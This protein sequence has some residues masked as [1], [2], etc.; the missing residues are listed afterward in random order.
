MAAPFLAMILLEISIRTECALFFIN[1]LS[2]G[3]LF[4]RRGGHGVPPLQT[5]PESFPAQIFFNLFLL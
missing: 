1:N 2:Q 5:C 4:E 3:S